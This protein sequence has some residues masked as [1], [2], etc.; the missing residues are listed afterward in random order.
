MHIQYLQAVDL[1]KYTQQKV[2]E[3]F[4][5]YSKVLILACTPQMMLM[6]QIV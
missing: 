5:F 6:P 3:V 2:M 1:L 4:H